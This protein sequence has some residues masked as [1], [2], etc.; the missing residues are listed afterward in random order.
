[1]EFHRLI[2]QEH[3][4]FNVVRGDLFPGGIK[5]KCVAEVFPQIPE[6]EVVYAGHAYGHSGYALGLAGLYHNKKVTLFF[7][8]PEVMTCIHAKARSLN[9]ITCYF[10]EGVA[11]QK[12]LAGL[13][14][15]YAEMRSAYYMP[16]GFE[17]KMFVEHLVEMARNLP[18]RPEEVWVAGGSGTTS[19]CLAMAWPEARINTVNLGMMP[20]A[21]MMGTVYQA[22]EKPT[23]RG[24]FPPPYPSSPWYDSKIW[25]FVKEHATKGALIWNIA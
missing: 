13:A 19:R 17:C 23:D 11:H 3:D 2:L 18:V 16:I 15:H 7:A 9:N 20:N 8:G 5:A 24:E 22:P 10:M 4:G 6:Q 12:N 1:M 21:L 14:E 25:R